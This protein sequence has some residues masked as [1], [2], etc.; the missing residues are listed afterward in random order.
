LELGPGT[1]PSAPAIDG[2]A[3]VQAGT[4]PDRVRLKLRRKIMKAALVFAGSGPIVILTS[5]PSLSD[6]GLLRALK[7]HGVGKFIAYELPLETV[8]ARYERRARQ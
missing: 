8:A 5:Y 2:G 7:A 3:Q 1:D 4:G 6:A